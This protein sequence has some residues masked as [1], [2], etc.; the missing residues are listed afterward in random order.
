MSNKPVS[1]P[2]GEEKPG[3][4]P[5]QYWSSSKLDKAQWIRARNT[6]AAKIDDYES[7]VESGTMMYKDRTVFYDASHAA[8]F[9]EGK[10]ETGTFESPCMRGLPEYVVTLTL[11]QT[12][13]VVH[14]T[15]P[16]AAP[17]PALAPAPAPA[18][19]TPMSPEERVADSGESDTLCY[20]R[21]KLV[22]L[23][24]RRASPIS[25]WIT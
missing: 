16:A 21:N 2:K 20:N 18:P 14:P 11:P 9:L 1:H 23:D 13:A 7:L 4:D 8:D 19:T 22:R 15:A 12:R 10:A 6:E 5:A 3:Y 25:T 24:K 17:G